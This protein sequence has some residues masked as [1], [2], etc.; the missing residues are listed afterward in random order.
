MSKKWKKVTSLTELPHKVLEAAYNAGIVSKDGGR[1]GS[2]LHLDQSTVFSKVENIFNK[3][4]ELLD[5][6]DALKKYDWLQDYWWKLVDPKKDEYTKKVEE[7]YSGGYFMRILPNTKITFPL[8]SCLLITEEGLEQKI[9]NIIIAEEGSDSHIITGCTLHPD[10]KRAAHLGITEIYVKENATLNFSMIH[11]WAEDTKVRPRSGIIIEEN[12][13]FISNYLS[14]RPVKDIQMYPM[15]TCK[16]DNSTATFNSIM[17]AEK[18]SN[19]DIGSKVIL[20]G[21]GSKTEIISRAI[22]KD[23]SLIITRGFLQ[24]DNNDCKGHLECRGLLI[25]TN[26]KMHAIPE[27]IANAEGCELSHEAAVGKIAEKEIAYLM[28]RGLS[29]EQATSAIIRGFLDISIMGLPP[30]LEKEIKQIMSTL[31]FAE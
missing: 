27:L 23:D 4:I 9:H 2:F 7:E 12:G 24:G 3:Q 5:I 22:S 25:G 21:M 6:K 31:K 18:N 30:E 17:Y 10:T 16:G 29:K 13:T 1:S 14:L 15:A 28:T 11:H 8:Q 26:A 20:K 19:L